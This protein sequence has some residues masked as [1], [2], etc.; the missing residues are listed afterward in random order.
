MSAGNQRSQ[1]KRG[2]G[3]AGTQEE[4]G[5]TSEQAQHVKVIR[6]S[7][8]HSIRVSCTVATAWPLEYTGFFYNCNVQVETK[9]TAPSEDL[10]RVQL[11]KTHKAPQ[12]QL[13]DDCLSVTG[14]K[15]YKTVRASHGA[16]SGAWYCEVTVKHL[17]STG[18][19]RLGWC[20]R[21]A[22]LN[23]PVGYDE[24]GLCYRDLEGSKVRNTSQRN[25]PGDWY[26]NS[27]VMHVLWSPTGSQRPA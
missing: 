23:A 4:L 20:T 11:S 24:F 2:R 19:V 16:H 12:L 13:S 1:K 10:S 25:L 27:T 7:E 9:A 3:G 22:E 21:K 6:V 14:H 17:G 5:L 18:H 15:G 8:L 26:L